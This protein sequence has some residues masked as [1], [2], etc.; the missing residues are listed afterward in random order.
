MSINIRLTKKEQEIAEWAIDV[1]LSLESAD[2]E[3]LGYT[4]S[5]IPNAYKGQ[6]LIR[7]P[8]ALNDLLYRVEDQYID[9][10]ETARRLRRL[11]GENVTQDIKY[12]RSLAEKI[13]HAIEVLSRPFPHFVGSENWI[14]YNAYFYR[15]M[16]DEILIIPVLAP[17][18]FLAVKWAMDNR[19]LRPFHCRA[20]SEPIPANM[21]LVVVG[22]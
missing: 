14:E 16:A 11:E 18:D 2:Y 4:P 17:D 10:A 12:A 3:Q 21:A 9:M 19:P 8:F 22:S 15:P 7:V 1:M 13:K 6:M 20:A 5:D